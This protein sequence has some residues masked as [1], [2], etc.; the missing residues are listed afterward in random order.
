MELCLSSGDLAAG[1]HAIAACRYFRQA[2]V[3]DLT[4]DGQIVVYA[5][6]DATGTVIARARASD[7]KQADTF[8][9]HGGVIPTPNGIYITVAGTDATG[10][11]IYQS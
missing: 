10:L 8:S 3:F 11:V 9:L 5:C 7:E 4:G 6:T 1:N 2:S